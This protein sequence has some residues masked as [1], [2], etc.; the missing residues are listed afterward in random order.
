M[1]AV[2]RKIS[3]GSDYK[4]D[5]MHYAVGQQV[6]GGHTITAILFSEKDSS[7]SIYIKKKDEVMPWKKFNSN[8]AISVE[9]DLEY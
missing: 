6:Y 1:G 8:M 5:A 4:N 7:Y 2:V 3:I 9:Y